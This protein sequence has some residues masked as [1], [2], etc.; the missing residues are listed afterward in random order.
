MTEIS[1]I[2]LRISQHK[3][4][5]SANWSRIASF[6]WENFLSKDKG[7][8][9]VTESD[10]VFAKSP[11]FAPIRFRYV[12][13]VD[14]RELLD[15]FEGSKEQD[16]LSTYDP[17]AK[18]IIVIVRHHGGISSYLIGASPNPPDAYLAEKTKQN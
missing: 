5:L 14:A 16:W 6:A 10:F 8:V 12:P 4:F 7:I 15:D 17:A 1:S 9:V 3:E 18:V 2:E 11:R 13:E